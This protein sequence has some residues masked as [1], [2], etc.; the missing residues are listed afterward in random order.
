MLLRHARLPFRHERR[1]TIVTRGPL[2]SKFF[3]LRSRAIAESFGEGKLME[4]GQQKA[5]FVNVGA[6]WAY[7]VMSTWV[8]EAV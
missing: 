3:R 1:E 4:E 8:G 2:L 7:F 6:R 5:T